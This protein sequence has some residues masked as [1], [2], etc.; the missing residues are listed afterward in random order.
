MKFD[1]LENLF[2]LTD[3]ECACHEVPDDKAYN[4][5]EST[6]GEY[7]TDYI[8]IDVAANDDCDTASD[9]FDD[10]NRAVTK[11]SKITLDELTNLLDKTRK[12]MPRFAR[13]NKVGTRT[14][15]N[16][17]ETPASLNG[18]RWEVRNS[19][20]VYA[21]VRSIEINVKTG[22]TALVQIYNSLGERLYSESHAVTAGWNTI[23]VNTLLSLF[24]NEEQPF[25]YYIVHQNT[26]TTYDNKADCGCGG[27]NATLK[28]YVQISGVQSTDASDPEAYSVTSSAWG[29]VIDVELDCSVERAFCDHASD[30]VQGVLART[31]LWRAAQWIAEEQLTRTQIGKSTILPAE[32]LNAKFQQAQEEYTKG[33]NW[34]ANHNFYPPCLPCKSGFER[35]GIKL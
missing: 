12:R 8:D 17:N 28:R 15:A 19:P 10:M 32:Q 2:G 22:T 7:L 35:R 5:T 13:I 4:I 14:K 3:K 24:H 6:S 31:I 33:L 29:T 27:A 20:G 18:V 26:V 34:L 25:Y 16:I 23:S 11:A 9:L 21:R 1:C 30:E